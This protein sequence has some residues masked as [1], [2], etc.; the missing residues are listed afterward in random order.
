MRKLAALAWI[1]VVVTACEEPK[2][3]AHH[4][5]DRNVERYGAREQ[6]HALREE[7]M[8]DCTRYPLEPGTRVIV[9]LDPKTGAATSA[10][11]NADNLGE[12]GKCIE[13]KFGRLKVE[14][15]A[16][17]PGSIEVDLGRPERSTAK[18]P[19]P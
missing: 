8:H 16:G 13:D 12:V 4:R 3:A 11:V 14:P 7:V 2:T 1:A 18:M 5:D 9:T 15:F 6:V 17:E 19:H 10:K